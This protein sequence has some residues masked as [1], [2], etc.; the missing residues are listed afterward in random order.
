MQAAIFLDRDGVLIEDVDLLV[1]PSEV[2]LVVGV[3]EALRRLKQ[4][5]FDLV[6]VTNQSVLARG[7]CSPLDVIAVHA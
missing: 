2:Q 6:M 1:S 3:P 5:G 4:A 7:L